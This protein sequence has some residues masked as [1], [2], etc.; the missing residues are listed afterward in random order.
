MVAYVIRRMLAMIPSLLGIALITFTLM[1]LT[2]GGPF[3]SEH[4]NPD[5]TARLMAAYHL[6]EPLW[7]NFAG[8]VPMSGGL[9]SPYWLPWR[10]PAA[11]SCAAA[12]VCSHRAPLW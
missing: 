2:K 5:I 7:P 4:T 9:P 12:S 8:G 6:D 10:L 3:S 1:H 11:S